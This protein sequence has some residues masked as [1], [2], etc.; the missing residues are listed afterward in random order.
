MAAANVR[1]Q[2]TGSPEPRS[3]ATR[4]S[5]HVETSL[6]IWPLPRRTIPC[7]TLLRSAHPPPWHTQ[8][9]PSVAPLRGLRYDPDMGLSVRLSCSAAGHAWLST[10]DDEV[11][12]QKVARQGFERTGTAARHGDG[13]HLAYALADHREVRAQ[14]HAQLAR[15][16]GERQ[17][18]DER[19]VEA[20]RREARAAVHDHVRH[21]ARRAVA[22]RRERRARRRNCHDEN[23]AYLTIE[24]RPKSEVHGPWRFTWHLT[25]LSAEKASLDKKIHL[26]FDVIESESLEAKENRLGNYF[27]NRG[28]LQ[29]LEND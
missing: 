19:V 20:R 28:G 16:R 26:P 12:V 15:A 23:N 27:V 13:Q 18:F 29:M 1:R 17:L 3:I 10:L 7:A 4:L 21:V 25:H 11:A 14:L 22:P 6:P 9:M 2:D 5:F 24:F 8:R